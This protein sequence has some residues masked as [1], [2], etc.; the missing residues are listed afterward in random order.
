MSDYERKYQAA[1]AELEQTDI[2]RSNYAP[3]ALRV[4]RRLGQQVR[5]PHYA[6]F[7]RTT[8]G[9]AFWFSGVW[10]ILMWFTTWRDQGFSG[11][12][13]VTSAALA[14]LMFGGVIAAYYA[15]SRRRYGLS[16]WD[17]L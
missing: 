15:W 5:P 2:W 14:G 6:P 17:D 11:A 4:Q 13:A 10:G 16:D 9:Y 1:I 12:S 8:C 3:L 7:L